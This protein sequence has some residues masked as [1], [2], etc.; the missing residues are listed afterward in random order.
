MT[1]GAGPSGSG[2]NQG[3]TPVDPASYI[4]AMRTFYVRVFSPAEKGVLTEVIAAHRMS[5]EECGALTF[6]T[7][8]LWDQQPMAYTTRAYNKEL[9]IDV[10]D[11]D[12]PMV[13]VV[14]SH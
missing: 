1:T 10:M 12:T 8:R 9:W 3:V 7:I 5:I 13:P 6:T 14:P 2:I 4:P 11:Q